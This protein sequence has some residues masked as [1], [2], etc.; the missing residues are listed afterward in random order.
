MTFS[1]YN[2]NRPTVRTTRPE[3][4]DI[5]AQRYQSQP[6]T[7]KSKKNTAN[8]FLTFRNNVK[9]FLSQNIMNNFQ[10]VVYRKYLSN[11]TDKT[12]K[13]QN[14]LLLEEQSDQ[15]LHCLSFYL[16]HLQIILQRKHK[17]FNFRIF[18]ILISGVPILR[19]FHLKKCLLIAFESRNSLLWAVTVRKMF[20]L[21]KQGT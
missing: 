2:T 5:F 18:S 12:M 9:I 10:T 4:C 6:I 7:K 19:G 13:T 21:A 11:R 20:L 1:D 17:L 16:L 15:D 3:K 8:I 14:R